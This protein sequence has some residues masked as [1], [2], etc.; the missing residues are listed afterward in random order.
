[1]WNQM[2]SCWVCE[3]CIQNCNGVTHCN[4]TQPNGTCDTGAPGDLGDPVCDTCMTCAQSGPCSSITN[5]CVNSPECVDYDQCRMDCFNMC[6][7]NQNGIEPGEQA[8]FDAC[9]GV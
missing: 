5:A 9:H 8:C 7:P 3:A 6:D 4:G 2:L 1:M